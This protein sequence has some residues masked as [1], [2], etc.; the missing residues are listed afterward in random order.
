[1]QLYKILIQNMN[2]IILILFLVLANISIADSYK[3]KFEYNVQFSNFSIA[4]L[5]VEVEEKNEKLYFNT[6]TLSIGVLKQFYKYKSNVQGFSEKKNGKFK[7]RLYKVK[8][9]Y[10]NKTM[11]TEVLWDSSK[12]DFLVNNIP[13][14]DFKKVKKIPKYSIINVTDPFSSLINIIY[15]L[16]INNSCINDI[17]VYDGRR[18]YD[19]KSI[20]ISREFLKK[21]RPNAYQGNVIVC[22]FRFFPIGGHRIESNWKPERDKFSE[23]K[24][25]FGF[26]NNFILPVRLEVQRWFGKIISRIVI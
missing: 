15:N 19:V 26:K 9:I 21:D 13:K 6:N 8:S 14:L 17:R 25:F 5:Y 4:K 12:A 23:I 1:M 20:E 10:K 18:R 2:F 22:G 7:T 24:I 11:K 3:K 16:K